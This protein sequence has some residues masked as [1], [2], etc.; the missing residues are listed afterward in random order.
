MRGLDTNVL[1]RFV[2]EDDPVQ[3][4]AARSLV[5]TLTA[6]DPGYAGLINTVEFIWVLRQT[7]GFDP[8]IVAQTLREL[9]SCVEFVFEGTPDIEAALF[10]SGRTGSDLA[11]ALIARRNAKAGC[12]ATYTLDKRASRI[13]GMELVPPAEP[14]V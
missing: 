1:V 6:D 14:G 9:L 2:V 7:Y 11:D 12:S 3:C 10:E 4:A 13:A 8:Q 5:A